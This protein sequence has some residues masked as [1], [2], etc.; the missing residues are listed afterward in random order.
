MHKTKHTRE[1][2]HCLFKCSLMFF[3]I[4]TYP[5]VSPY[6]TSFSY[7]GVQHVL[8][9]ES[10]AKFWQKYV[11]RPL[12]C[13]GQAGSA[14]LPI[15][16]SGSNRSQVL[17]SQWTD[18]RSQ[19]FEGK[20]NTSNHRTCDLDLN[21]S[22]M[23]EAS[24]MW[25]ANL[26]RQSSSRC[27]FKSTHGMS[28]NNVTW[29]GISDLLL[30]LNYGIS[31]RWSTVSLWWGPSRP[32]DKGKQWQNWTPPPQT[33]LAIFPLFQLHISHDFTSCNTFT[34]PTICKK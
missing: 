9:H 29:Q 8:Q 33:L 16:L 26:P 3:S 17:P 28:A 7:G 25:A 22:Q 34:V 20:W 14:L 30:C 21:P 19:V 23:E 32:R 15:S 18:H 12:C 27:L 10:D 24:W 4:H 13:S 2:Q 11:I 31:S 5:Y 6:Y 1:E